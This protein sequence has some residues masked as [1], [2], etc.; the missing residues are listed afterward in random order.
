LEGAWLPN[1]EEE[2][3][4]EESAI[5]I[6]NFYYSLILFVLIIKHIATNKPTELSAF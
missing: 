2:E 3:E 6:Q 1:Q 4:E 5:K